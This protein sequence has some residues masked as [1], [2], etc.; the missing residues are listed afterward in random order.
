MYRGFAIS[1][2]LVATL[3]WV[4]I[5]QRPSAAQNLDQQRL[6]TWEYRELEV[7]G[8]HFDRAAANAMGQEGWELIETNYHH[9]EL[10]C[11]WKRLR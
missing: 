8:G 11:I 6:P 3:C 4:T 5:S 7:H 10:L 9:G 2:V 1:G